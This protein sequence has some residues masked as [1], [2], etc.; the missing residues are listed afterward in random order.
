M[1]RCVGCR[2]V[3]GIRPG[4]HKCTVAIEEATGAADYLACTVEGCAESFPTKQ[5]LSNHLRNHRL[6]A[7]RETAAVPLP[8]PATRQQLRAVPV[9][10]PTR[11][12]DARVP[13]DQVEDVPRIPAGDRP[14]ATGGTPPLPPAEPRIPAGNRPP[15]TGGSVPDMN[16]A[17]GGVPR[18]PA[19]NRPPDT[20]GPPLSPQPNMLPTVATRGVPRTPAG[21][22]PPDTGGPPLSPQPNMLPTARDKQHR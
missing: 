4:A 14:P 2:I 9:R 8:A 11:G 17:T 19:G 20:G 21:N 13:V 6:R 7:A 5:G 1:V 22:R 16:V 15:D 3:L 12:G 18:I 10:R